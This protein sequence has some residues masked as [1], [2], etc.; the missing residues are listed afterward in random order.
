MPSPSLQKG[1]TIDT[2]GSEASIDGAVPDQCSGPRSALRAMRHGEALDEAGE[3]T[4][5][6]RDI[7]YADR[8]R[9]I[10]ADAVL[11]AQ[12]EH[13]DWRNVAHRHAVVAGA[14]RQVMHAHP[15]GVDR[16]GNLALQAGRARGGARIP[17]WRHVERYVAARG[18][19][20]EL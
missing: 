13:A 19:R 2:R 14:R 9:R 3:H 10:V 5:T 6:D 20:L 1:T 15:F 17:Q 12:E 11:A 8:L 16:F 7:L 18:D 4:G